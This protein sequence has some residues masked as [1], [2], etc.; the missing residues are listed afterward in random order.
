MYAGKRPAYA[1]VSGKKK[2]AKQAGPAFAGAGNSANE[3]HG[4]ARFVTK[5]SAAAVVSSPLVLVFTFMALAAF[6]KQAPEISETA[7]R[8][9]DVRQA[10]VGQPLSP[11]VLPTSVPSNKKYYVDQAV[12][13]SKVAWLMETSR[14]NVTGDALSNVRLNQLYQQGRRSYL[15]HTADLEV[16][17]KNRTG[18]LR[19]GRV[20]ML[21]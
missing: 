5:P 1:A 9:V 18:C 12:Y 7:K 20:C 11:P 13:A 8:Y 4:A 6:W 3:Q 19:A 2:Q 10:V 21:P 15:R 17:A 16:R 14:A